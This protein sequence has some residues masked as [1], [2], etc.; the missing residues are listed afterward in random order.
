M[1][2]R[3]CSLHQIIEFRSDSYIHEKVPVNNENIR[4]K[5]VKFFSMI[6]LLA[7]MSQN[8]EA[9]RILCYFPP[10]RGSETLPA[11]RM[12]PVCFS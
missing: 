7:Y 12:P 1:T 5:N 6:K 9:D 2:S 11:K 3:P 8:I 10:V 4:K